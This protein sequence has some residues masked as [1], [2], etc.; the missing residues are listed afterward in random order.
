MSQNG[1]TNP[2]V[3]LQEAC[4]HI[5]VGSLLFV[6]IAIPAVGLDFLVSGLP[7]VG[8]SARIAV[9]LEIAEYFL[10]AADVILLVCFTI[11]TGWRLLKTL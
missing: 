6:L 4:V 2:W 8:V 3:A 5:A 9:G 7:K 1:I 11:R 10:F